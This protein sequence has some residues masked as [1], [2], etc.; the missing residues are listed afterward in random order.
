M[1]AVQYYEKYKD[2]F[3]FDYYN[4][5]IDF[6]NELEFL[7]AIRHIKFDAGILATIEELNTKWNALVRIFESASTNGYPYLK[8]DGFKLLLNQKMEEV[9]NEQKMVKS[10]F[11]TS[12]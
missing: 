7:I 2:T 11:D 3:P 6:C 9:T 8:K 1:K 5:F 4:L 10:C 12:I